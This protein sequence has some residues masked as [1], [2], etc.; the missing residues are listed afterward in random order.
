MANKYK[1][2]LFAVG[3]NT[4][5]RNVYRVA[6]ILF[7]QRE[8]YSRMQQNNIQNV[9]LY[10]LFA[11]RSALSIGSVVISCWHIISFKQI[12]FI[13]NLMLCAV[14]AVVVAVLMLCSKIESISLCPLYGRV[15]NS[16]PSAIRNFV[17]NQKLQTRGN[18][19]L[20]TLPARASNAYILCDKFL[21]APLAF[22]SGYTWLVC[23]KSQQN[24]RF[25]RK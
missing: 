20:V 4:S 23:R 21:S 14:V 9:F 12:L 22:C 8:I 25:L 13:L 15:T 11:F 2:I 16:M 1:L 5:P 17:S 24:Y 10:I 7:I 19:Q 18:G 3:Y 6:Y